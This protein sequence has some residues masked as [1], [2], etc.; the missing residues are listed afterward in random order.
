M[1]M[2]KLGGL[3][4][5]RLKF[6]Y[7][8]EKK[9]L[10]DIA[11]LFGVS[12]AAVY[13]RLINFK[14]PQRSKSEAR[15]EAQKKGKFFQRY[16][17]INENFFSSWSPEMAYVL[18]LIATD[19]CITRTGRISLSMNEEGLLEKVKRVMGSE[20]N[21]TPSKHQKGLYYFHFA[22]EKLVEDLSRLGILPR[23]S[24]NIK[25]PDVPADY[26]THFIRGIFD[27]DGSVMLSKQRKVLLLITKFYS[28]SWDFIVRLES[29][30]QGLGLPKRRI[31]Q[32]KTKNG[33]YYS[34]VYGHEDSRALF[35]IL[36]KNTENKL[37][38]E[39][40]YKRFLEGLR[41]AQNG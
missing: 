33:A 31:Y 7:L 16:Y 25:F 2:G 4:K 19:G 28:G 10:D 29:S 8:D 35:K 24:L 12:R 17:D 11:E 1:N 5:E 21:I 26:I 6:L 32:Q 40:K 34:I 23:K 41:E 37:F 13:K 20:H 9:S 22:R 36:Y 14:I 18:G 38:L 15:L 39:R 30:L 27:G 3:G